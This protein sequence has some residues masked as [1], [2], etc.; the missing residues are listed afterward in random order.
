MKKTLTRESARYFKTNQIQ[1]KTIQS[2]SPPHQKLLKRIATQKDNQTKFEYSL[3]D[4]L[5]KP[6][7]KEEVKDFR[8]EIE[9]RY[10]KASTNKYYKFP[11]NFIQNEDSN[12]NTLNDSLGNISMDSLK[13]VTVYDLSSQNKK[14]KILMN[15]VIPKI[16]SYVNNTDRNIHLKDNNHVKVNRIMTEAYEEDIEKPIEVQIRDKS[17]NTYKKLIEL[18]EHQFNK[19]SHSNSAKKKFEPSKMD[20]TL[21][22]KNDVD[23]QKLVNNISKTIKPS[24]SESRVVSAFKQ[25]INSRYTNKS[26]TSIQNLKTFSQEKVKIHLDTNSNTDKSLNHNS[27]S[28]SGTKGYYIYFHQIV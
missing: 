27:H 3:Q 24:D 15:K 25:K 11:R 1:Q 2:Q 14:V 10:Q 9:K 21:N 13:Y 4:T 26:G 19:G 5:I 8:T 6:D 28:H 7:I 22:I 18:L 16:N 17:S 12:S 20:N 23:R